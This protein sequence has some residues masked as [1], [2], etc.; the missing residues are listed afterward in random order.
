MKKKTKLKP[1]NT[2]VNIIKEAK[3]IAISLEQELGSIHILLS[4]FTI[5]NQ[6]QQILANNQINELSIIKKINKYKYFEKSSIFS[7]I[8]NKTEY[9]TVYYKSRVININYLLLAIL[10]NENCFAYKIINQNTNFLKI[11]ECLIKL[12]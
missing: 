7:E 2:L 5:K 11:K 12:L 10:N 6:A 8:L 1:D 4:I 9:Y 3:K